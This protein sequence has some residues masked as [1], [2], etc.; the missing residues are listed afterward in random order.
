MEEKIR[1]IRN[2]RELLERCTHMLGKVQN[3]DAGGNVAE[4]PVAVIMMGERC[5]GYISHIR[6]TLMDNWNNAQ[7]LRY[8]SVVK[9]RDG[10]HCAVLK[11]TE[12]YGEYHWQEMEGD[13]AEN[14]KREIQEMLQSDSKIFS[15]RTHVKLEYVLDATEE[16]SEAY[17]RLF[18]KMQNGL[19]VTQLKT[20]YLMLDQRTDKDQAKSS[21]NL[22]R[23]VACTPEEK[24]GGTV[25]LLSNYMQSG[26]M[27]G[28]YT[29]WENYRLI[30]DIILLGG[31]KDESEKTGLYNGMKTVSYAIVSKPTDEIAFVL[32]KTLLEELYAL[33]DNKIPKEFNESKIREQLGFDAGNELNLS[34]EVFDKEISKEFPA[35]ENFRF[36]PFST[37]KGYREAERKVKRLEAREVQKTVDEMT[38]SAASTYIKQYYLRPVERFLANKDRMETCRKK[39]RS[40]LLERF[41]FYDFLF[42]QNTGNW[43]RVKSLLTAEYFF[44]GTSEKDGLAAKLDAWA[45]YESKKLFCDGIKP[46]YQEELK[47]LGESAEALTKHYGECRNEID[48]A[49]IASEKVQ[50]SVEQ[51]YPELVKKFVRQKSAFPEV[52][53]AVNSKEG[54]LKG[55]WNI[56]LELVEMYKEFQYAFE[57]ELAFRM[58]GISE[59][60]RD[61]IVKR[62]LQNS[63]DGSIRLKNAVDMNL[64]T[65][66][67]SYYLINE[68]AAYANTLKTADG[69]GRNYVLFNLKRTDCIEQIDIYN[70]D[71]PE[72]LQLVKEDDEYED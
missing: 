38:C 13:F 70:I 45:R 55:L 43:E 26:R 5:R 31:N 36:L 24:R 34:K 40:E 28:E 44:S 48:R 10:F 51:V 12:V 37:P 53:S 68:S 66:I 11:E 54:L 6:N 21:D 50:Q 46:I 19:L 41:S 49:W 29:M 67:K 18:Q 60:D 25:Y 32:L 56:F 62:E 4:Y 52:F 16:E 71:K 65:R 33:K 57:E 47:I 22:M 69:Y 15:I 20:L 27:L 8:L 39:V 9:K 17:Y 35:L 64:T 3:G 42:L 2:G 63:L 7:F 30:A 1:S 59:A 58:S 23:L 72:L 14:L 61:L